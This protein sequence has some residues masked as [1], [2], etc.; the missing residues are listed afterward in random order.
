M[1]NTKLNQI[2]KHS[3]QIIHSCQMKFL[4]FL[5]GREVSYNFLNELLYFVWYESAVKPL[6]YF[7]SK[8][9]YTG[10]SFFLCGRRLDEWVQHEEET[11]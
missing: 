1:K 5:Q 8:I 7:R 4:S 6:F 3:L 2:L 9:I 11:M 10:A